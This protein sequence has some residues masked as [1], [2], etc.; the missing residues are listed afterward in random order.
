MA[1]ITANVDAWSS[2]EGS[3]SPSGS[4]TIGS[5]LDDNLRAAQAGVVLWVERFPH[6]HN[7]ALEASVGSNALTITLSGKDSADPSSTNKVRVPFRNVTAATGDFAQVVVSAATTLTVSSGSTLGT[8]D[9]TAFR[10]WI[11]GFN[12]GGTF[13]LGA[14]NCLSGTS[15]YPLSAWGI[16]SST[17]EGGAGASD[18]AQVFY[19]GTAVTSKAYTVLGY[20]TWETGLTTAGTWDAVPTR[21]QLF[22]A[23]V[24]LPGDRVQVKRTATGAM[25][26]GTTNMALDDTIPQNTEGTEFMTQAITPT[27]AANVLE[28]EALAQ[29]SVDSG[30][31]A[32]IAAL[33]QDSTADALVA[34]AGHVDVSAA[35]LGSFKYGSRLSH[36]MLAAT[37]SA[38]TFKYRA[39]ETASL[40]LTFNGAAG[41]RLFGGVSNSYMQAQEIMA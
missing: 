9:G 23:G 13:R 36:S 25:A 28:I 15:I 14:I 20:M 21:I 26:T 39:G 34:A 2:T 41:A 7:L 5:G 19:T 22:G 1:D 6:I 33:F 17:A 11:V 29:L 31:S 38:T 12:D 32:V 8:F 27:S 35:T 37:T 10:L 40:T 16:A 30:N 4:T 18:S 3:N 24:R